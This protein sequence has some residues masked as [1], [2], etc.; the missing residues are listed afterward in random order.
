MFSSR[1]S[2]DSNDP[3]VPSTRTSRTLSAT[4]SV[5]FLLLFLTFSLLGQERFGSFIGT[6]TDSSGAVLPNAAIT[7]TNKESHREY[8]TVSDSSGGYIFRQIEPGRYSFLFE[9]PGFSKGEVVDALVTVGQ[10][11]KV[12]MQLQVGATQ[13]AVQ[14]SETAPLI[15]TAGV[16]RSNNINAEEFNNLPKSRS[17]QSLALLAPSVNSGQIEGGYQI[18]G[19]SGAENQF[20]IDGV[21]TNS[22]VDGRSRQNSAFEFV[23][24]VQVLTGGIDAQYGGATGGVINAVTRSGGNSFHGE[25][26]YYYF[27][28]AISAGPVQRLLLLN[29]FTT[30]TNPS[31]QQDYKPQNDNHEFG[32]SVGGPILKDKLFFFSSYSP[33]ILRRSQ[34]YRF[35]NGVDPDTLT[36]KSTTQQLFNKVTY[37]PFQSLRVN[38]NWLWTPTRTEGLLPAYDGYGN[39]VITSKASVQPLKTQGWTQPQSNY[40]AQIDWTISPT[41]M[42]TFKGGRFWDNFHTWGIP[43]VSS[44]TFQSSPTGITGLP[45]DLAGQQQ[46]YSTTP[47]TQSTFFDIATRSYFNVDASKYVSSFWGSHDI[48]GG[49]GLI[50]NVNKVDVSYPGGGYVYVYFNRPFTPTGALNTPVR[51]TYGYYEV[52]NIGTRG[53]TGGTMNSLY[54]QDHWR[55]HPRVTLTLGLR[56]ENEHVPSFVRS[57]RDDAFAFGFQ[58]KISPRVGVSW[59]VLGN[60]KLKAFGSYNRLYN[61]IPYELSRGSFGGDFWTVNYRSLDTLDIRSLSGTNL[62][63][64]N[65]WP[66]GAFRDRRVPNFNS[67]DPSL[68]PFA[69]DLVNAGVEY[70]LTSSTVVRASFVRNDLVRAIEDQGTLVNGDEVYQY[71]NP[72]YGVAKTFISSGATPTGFATPKAK[73]TYTAME[74]SVTRRFSRG[75]SGGASYVRSKLYG[76]YAGLGNSDEILTPTSGLSSA[77]TQQSGGSI[78]RPGGSATRAWDLDEVLFDSKGNFVYGNLATDRPNVFKMYGSYTKNWSPRFGSSDIGAFFYGASGTP[79][80]TTVTTSNGIETFVNGR[81]DLGR[82]PH[83]TQTDLM[84]AHEFKFGETKRIRFEA[85]ATNVFNQKTA[86]HIFDWLNRGVG[87]TNAPDSAI[88]L[89]KVNLFNGYNYNALIQGT[90]AGSNAY[91]PRFGKADL[92]N[93]GFQGRLLVKFIF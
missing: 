91:D 14:V 37:T 42:L 57:I 80:S 15:D 34:D 90:S 17:F 13:T 58:D 81:G 77:T 78:A 65:L 85:N 63:G 55:I 19:A 60:G 31:F 73:R 16:T 67:V 89:S 1:F 48:K 7:L 75:F 92:W 36:Q 6:V 18:N 74:L 27:G 68:K 44:I 87:S 26:H 11:I 38:A 4:C 69:T 12:D 22:L 5:S 45:S 46:G 53:S 79:L 49:Y 2:V 93:A 51:G 33:Q 71:V 40:S 32:G 39:S 62:P 21:T 8:K 56:T 83:L 23:Q 64:R 66:Y 10:Q 29:Q 24:E 54:L 84:V 82:T 41:V 50:K 25:A 47:R 59:D 86:R 61:W 43:P 9:Q 72:G 30:G 3:V 88:N 70:Q 20:F 28:N 35:G 76:N 52:D